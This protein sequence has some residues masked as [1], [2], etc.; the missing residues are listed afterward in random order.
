M[1]ELLEEIKKLP[2]EEQLALIQQVWDLEGAAPIEEDEE[3]KAELVRRAQYAIDNPQSGIP[4]AEVKAR[5]LEKQREQS[6]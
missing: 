6:G 3:F 4:W 1:A 5:L 2:R